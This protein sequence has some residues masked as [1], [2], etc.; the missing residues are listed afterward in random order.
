MPKQGCILCSDLLVP[1]TSGG[2]NFFD[3]SDWETGSG[4]SWE[5]W[6]VE[7]GIL[8]MTSGVN[9]GGGSLG[10]TNTAFNVIQVYPNPFNNELI[11]NSKSIPTDVSLYNI[12][13]SKINIEVQD[14]FRIDTS[15]L[16][17]G[18]YFLKLQTEGSQQ[19][20]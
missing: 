10:I 15:F 5:N 6:F 14:N 2:A 18:T 1:G 13:G 8:S 16:S 3:L 19:T 11:I 12:L 17:A 7:N 9:P 20:F 4:G